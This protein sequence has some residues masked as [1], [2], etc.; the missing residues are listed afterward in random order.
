MNLDDADAIREFAGTI[1]DQEGRLS[2]V[3]WQMIRDCQILTGDARS[4]EL[5]VADLAAVRARVRAAIE[6]RRLEANL[7]GQLHVKGGCCGPSSILGG[8]CRACGS[9]LHRQP[10]YSGIWDCC[11]R[12]EDDAGNWLP[13]GTFRCRGL[14]D[15]ER[16]VGQAGDEVVGLVGEVT[17]D[18]VGERS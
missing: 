6:A 12:C 15:R 18:V 9:R 17:D 14:D 5:A 4:E 3:D 10:I 11:E 7:D 1:L 13:R 8:R 2:D 16:D